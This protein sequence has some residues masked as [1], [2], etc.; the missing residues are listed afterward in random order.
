MGDPRPYVLATD[1]SG[2]TWR[3]IVDGLPGDQYV[4]VVR[5]DPTNPDVLYAGLEQGVWFSLDRGAH[6]HSLRLNMPPVAVHDL[7]VQPQRHDLLVATHGRGFWILDD[8][9]AIAGLRKAVEAGRT[10]DLPAA[11][12]VHVV[13][14]VDECVRNASGR[15]LRC[16]RGV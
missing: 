9:G 12:G 8:A 3:S 10:G 6:W 14:L 4:H 1:D 5:E 2:A 16:S 7:R 11:H 13:P 15:V